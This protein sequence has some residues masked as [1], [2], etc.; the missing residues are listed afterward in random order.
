[1]H[2]QRIVK[3]DIHYHYLSHK[4]QNESI[5]RFAKEIKTSIVQKVQKAKYFSIILDCM[6]DISRK[7]QMSIVVRCVDVSQTPTKLE[8]FFLGFLQVNDT[9]GAGLFLELQDALEKLHLNIYNIRGQGYGNGANMKG[10]RKGVQKKLINMNPR[11]FYTPCGCHSLNL[12]LCD[13]AKSCEKAS[14]FFGI[15]QTTYKLFPASTKRWQVFKKNRREWSHS[16]AIIGYKVGK[17][18]GKHQS[19]YISSPED[20]ER[21]KHLKKNSDDDSEKCVVDGLI[22]LHFKNFEFFLRMVIWYDL[23]SDVNSVSKS[24][25]KQDMHMATAIKH[26]NKL[27]SYFQGYRDTGFESAMKEATNIA[28]SMGVTPKF[29][30]I[31]VRKRKKHF[32]EGPSE[33]P[34]PSSGEESFKTNY[35]FYI[36]DYALRSFKEIFAQFREYERLYRFLFDL[37][38]LKSMNNEE[39]LASCKTLEE[40]LSYGTIYDIDG[41]DLYA[42][43]KIIRG[44]IST[45]IK[46]PIEVLHFLQEMEGCYPNAWIAYRILFTVPVTVASAERSFSQLKLIKTYLQSTMLQERLNGLAMIAIE[47]EIA[48]LLD[49]KPIIRDFASE[50]A[51]RAVFTPT[52]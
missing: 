27:I 39:L 18:C 19:Y 25:Q 10:K 30:E 2:L 40:Y 22:K 37:E 47:R 26:I 29:R 51:R 20:T 31:R 48:E 16:Q 5:M 36:I 33:D 49:Y 11:A 15:V 44:M 28:T 21:S 42:E 14:S 45:D 41:K 9:T 38:K 52:Q 6:P 32:D 17:S 43:L 1:M 24:M 12:I 3:K 23:L 35:F 13:M 50:N 8:E 4:I 46:K 34:V 7:E